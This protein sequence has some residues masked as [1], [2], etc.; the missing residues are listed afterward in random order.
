MAKNLG[1]QLQ[2]I[3]GISGVSAGSVASA[4]LPVNQRYHGLILNCTGINYTGGVAQVPTIVTAGGFANTTGTVRLNVVNGV[5]T[6][7]TYVAGNSGGATTATVLSVPDVTGAAPILLTCT[8]A[9]TGALGNATFTVG[10]GTAGPMPPSTLITS[11]RLLVNSVTIR[12]I[13][14]SQIQAIQTA[15]G[16]LAQYGSLPI[17][18]T[19]PWRKFLRDNELTSW[20]L[21]L[22]SSFQLQIGIS[23]AVTS[24]G[25]TGVMAFDNNRNARAGTAAQTTAAISAGLIASGSPVGTPIPFCQIVAQH[26]QTVAITAGRY[27][28]VTLPWNNPTVRLWLSGSVPGNIYQVEVIADAG[29]IVYQATAQ[30]MFEDAAEWGFQLGNPFY[31]PIAGGG[32]GAS[33]F[34]SIANAAPVTIP[35]GK[36]ADSPWLTGTNLFPLDGAVIFDIDNRPWKALKVSKGLILRVYSNVA[37]NLSIIQETLPGA[38]SG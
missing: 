10:A 20:D 1:R 15:N 30:Q 28:I 16:Y 36:L 7:V 21:A 31:A 34:G 22:Q 26:S 14:V 24:P 17:T 8:A 4:Q 23:A 11:L 35:N 12:D 2:F 6:S 25:I 29:N 38:F 9:G 19:E 5:P 32:F 37:Q 13:N 3:S 33:N 27:D 18:F